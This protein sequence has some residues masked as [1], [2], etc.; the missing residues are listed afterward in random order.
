MHKKSVHDIGTQVWLVH[1]TVKILS[2]LA[3]ETTSMTLSPLNQ[4]ENHQSTERLDQRER[5][6]GIIAEGDVLLR[7]IVVEGK[8]FIVFVVIVFVMITCL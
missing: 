4:I 5:V 3:E 6:S 1:C 8:H 7:H 2:G